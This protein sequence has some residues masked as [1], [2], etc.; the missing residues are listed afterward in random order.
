MTTTMTTTMAQIWPW[1][2]K[3]PVTRAGQS[4]TPEV[5]ILKGTTTLMRETNNKM[6]KNTSAA[7]SN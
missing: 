2:D 4:N 6:R 7:E 5:S 3:E 1:S